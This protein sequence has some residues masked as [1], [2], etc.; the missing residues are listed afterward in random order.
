MRRFMSDEGN[1]LAAG[2]AWTSALAWFT[3]LG[4]VM[5][6]IIGSNHVDDLQM[7][8]MVVTGRNGG[9]IGFFVGVVVAIIVTVLYPRYTR[10][11]ADEEA[12]GIDHHH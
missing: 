1:F 3:M 12:I 2:I 8:D 5:G 10:K 7:K 9:I 11:D 6:Q 4:F